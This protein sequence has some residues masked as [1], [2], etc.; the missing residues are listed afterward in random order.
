[1]ISRPPEPQPKTGAE[2]RAL[3]AALDEQ[4]RGLETSLPNEVAPVAIWAGVL[5]R[6]RRQ[7][8]LAPL[9]Q[10]IEVLEPPAEITELPGT[11]PWV[12]GVANNRGTLLPIF[13]LPALAYGETSSRRDT[14]RILVVRQDE[15]PCGLLVS[16]AIGIRHF[17]AGKQRPEPPPG[18]DI[19]AP[20]V[21]A[22][23]QLDGEP[24]P[25]LSLDRL[26]SD[27]LLSAAAQ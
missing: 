12:L 21:E 18:L 8:F 19:L 20:F 24:I 7:S 25:V 10:I 2:L 4:Y 16:A 14:D 9:G 22:A 17:E 23:Y 11:K 5:F 6:V 1:M 15:P 27:P 13:D 3:I 26:M